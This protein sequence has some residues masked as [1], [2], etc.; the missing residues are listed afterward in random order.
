[1]GY[2]VKLYQQAMKIPTNTCTAGSPEQSGLITKDWE[3]ARRA[4]D[5]NRTV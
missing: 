2:I 3:E 4:M 1:M 5:V